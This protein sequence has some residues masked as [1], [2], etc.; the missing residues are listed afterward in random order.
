MENR[1]TLLENRGRTKPKIKQRYKDTKKTRTASNR[2]RQKNKC[3]RQINVEQD[4]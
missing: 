4:Q 2:L 3:P 1:I